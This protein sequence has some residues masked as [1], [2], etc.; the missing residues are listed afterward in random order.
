MAKITPVLASLAML[1]TISACQGPTIQQQ[2]LMPAKQS[3]MQDAKVLAVVGFGQGI[4][5][6][7]SSKLEAHLANIQVQGKSY[8]TLVDR[9]RLDTVLEE[10]R[11]VNDSGLFDETYATRLGRLVGADTIIS[12]QGSKTDYQITKET[13]RISQCQESNEKGKCLKRAMKDIVCRRY[14]ARNE[15]TF[16]AT[17]VETGRLVFAKNYAGTATHKTC[18]GSQTATPTRAELTDRALNKILRELRYDVAPYTRTSHITLKKD[19]DSQL[20]KDKRAKEFF[21]S[22]LAFADAGRMDRACNLFRQ[23]ASVY[24]QSPAIYHNVGVCAE[25]EGNLDEALQMHERADLLLLKPDRLINQALS[26]VRN[27]KANEAK[28]QQQLR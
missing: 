23:A 27:R 5:S 11:M 20:K 28:A 25:T 15:I 18:P 17:S 14:N 8:F 24:S 2:V 10:Q 21:K 16:R 3:G 7:Q 12:G 4:N 1:F 22:G 9:T 26:R 6:T 13:Q 19:D